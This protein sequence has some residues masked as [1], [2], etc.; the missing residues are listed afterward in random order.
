MNWKSKHLT[1]YIS[2][3]G[4]TR[5][6]LEPDFPRKICHIPKYR[7]TFLILPI[8]NF[9]PRHRIQYFFF[10][11]KYLNYMKNVLVR[12]KLVYLVRI[13]CWVN[14]FNLNPKF[15]R[16]STCF[17]IFSTCVKVSTDDSFAVS[18]ATLKYFWE[19]INTRFVWPCHKADLGPLLQC[20]GHLGGGNTIYKRVTRKEIYDLRECAN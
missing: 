3:K 19:K 12:P 1:Q 15:F 6:A 17:G 10:D 20:E 13:Y 9:P 5:G 14:S 2:T 7:K 16:V 18:A 11:W 8:P 4:P